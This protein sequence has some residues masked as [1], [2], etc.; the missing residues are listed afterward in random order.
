MAVAFGHLGRGVV[1][2]SLD[3]AGAPADGVERYFGDF[4]S[5]VGARFAGLPKAISSGTDPESRFLVW[6]AGH[7]RESMGLQALGCRSERPLHKAKQ[8]PF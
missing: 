8:S 2:A 4:P 1:L 5:L 7:I 3:V 6:F